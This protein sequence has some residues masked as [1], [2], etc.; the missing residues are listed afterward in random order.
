MTLFFIED[1]QAVVHNDVDLSAIFPTLDVW[2]PA[3]LLAGLQSLRWANYED[4]FHHIHRFIGPALTTIVLEDLPDVV[5]MSL[6]STLA[7]TSPK[8][9][10]VTIPDCDS[11]ILDTTT[12][13]MSAFICSLQCAENVF[14]PCL[15][16][17]ALEHLGRLPNLK[18]LLLH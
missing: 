7:T 16:Q 15:D 6:L 10:T 1:P 17:R 18:T 9:K 13:S 8:L 14:V 2:L 3:N 5:M 4:N 12:R 11:P